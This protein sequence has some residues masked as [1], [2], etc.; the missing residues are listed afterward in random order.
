MFGLLD[1]GFPYVKYRYFVGIIIGG[2]PN[3]IDMAFSNV[4]GL[5][6]KRKLVRQANMTT[7]ADGASE[8]RTLTLKR[9]VFGGPSPLTIAQLLQIPFFQEKLLRYDI[10][11]SCMNG[12]GIP[13]ASWAVG[14]A[15][16]E[17]WEW[18]ALDANENAVLTETM[19]LRYSKLIYIPGIM[20]HKAGDAGPPPEFQAAALPPETEDV[21]FQG[22]WSVLN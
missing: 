13:T 12:D 17:S 5:E 4:S 21:G 19:K 2:V 3:P 14:E 22:A 11:I 15:Y 9:G 16:L 6:Y 10:L 1:L 7:F 20:P 8:L 18:D